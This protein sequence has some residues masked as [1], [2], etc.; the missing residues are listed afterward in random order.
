[1][2]SKKKSAKGMVVEWDLVLEKCDGQSR[3]HN[4]HACGVGGKWRIEVIE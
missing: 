1:M 2:F 4:S 3:A